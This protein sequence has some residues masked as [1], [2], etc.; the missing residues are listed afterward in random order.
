MTQPS[1]TFL[2]LGGSLITDKQQAL[3]A[4]SATILRL[5]KEIRSSINEQPDLHL[6]IGHGSG[7]FGHGVA[8]QYQTQAGEKGPGYW[9]GF[10][11]VWAAARELNQIVIQHLSSQN[12][13]VIA[14][15]PSAGIVASDKILETWDV[16]P[17]K[18][19]IEHQL[20]PIVQ[21][22]V[23]F[24]I[25]IGGTIFSTEQVFQHLCKMLQPNRILIAGLEHGVYL[26]PKKPQEVIPRITPRNFCSIVPAIS[27]AGTADVTGG[28]LSKVQLMLELIKNHPALEVQIFSGVT[29]GN[30]HKVLSG[31]KLGTLITAVD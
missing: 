16:L 18:L 27:G 20:I 2:K 10:A 29:P 15:P 24:D 3:T 5:A 23:V 14:F 22:D 25:K 4:Q 8:V 6:L 28:M 13:P 31:E 9:Q 7:S 11:A 30:V 17:I 19:A 1:L 12:L 21:G 26:D